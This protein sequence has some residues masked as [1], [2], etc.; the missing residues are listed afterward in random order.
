MNPRAGP[1]SPERNLD[2]FKG[3]G[4]ELHIELED[5]EDEEDE[6]RP[7]SNEEEKIESPSDIPEEKKELP[8]DNQPE[9]MS[10]AP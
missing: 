4:E 7:P 1:F 10:K 2:D 5:P 9:F 6:D 8:P 3:F